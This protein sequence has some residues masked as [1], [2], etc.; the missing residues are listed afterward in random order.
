[1]A[2]FLRHRS[3]TTEIEEIFWKAKEFIVV[4]SPYLKVPDDLQSRFKTTAA[5]LEEVI[6]IYGKEEELH[7]K[8][9]AFL[10][11]LPK[12]D[13]LYCK[14]LHAKCYLNEQSAVITSL[15]LYDFSINNNIEMGILI[16][17]AQDPEIYEDIE[18]EVRHIV[19]QS[20]EPAWRKQ[21][22]IVRRF[23]N[24]MKK[25]EAQA[26]CIRCKATIDKN[27]EKPF[28]K[29][30]LEKSILRPNLNDKAQHAEA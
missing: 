22:S 26:F 4:V 9:R 20:Q 23:F 5:K 8:T 1:M 21:K 3:I 7:E 25:P 18:N 17:K 15:N 27:T 13:V 12:T 6:V 16:S 28:C 2:K 29:D 14:N 24:R 19:E 10:N 11:E 30:C